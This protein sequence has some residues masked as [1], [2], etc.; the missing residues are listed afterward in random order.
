MDNSLVAAGQMI[1]NR[2]KKSTKRMYAGYI[3]KFKNWGVQNGLQI[4]EDD[5]ELILPI[6]TDILMRFF[7]FIGNNGIHV[8]DGGQLADIMLVL[9]V[10]ARNNSTRGACAVLFS[11]AVSLQTESMKC[12]TDEFHC[13]DR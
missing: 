3:R 5:G 8:N 11:V 13:V 12:E 6:D 9:T 4:V 7:S 1:E 2:I 10:R